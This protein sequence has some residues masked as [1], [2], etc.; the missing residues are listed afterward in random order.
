MLSNN[1]QQASVRLL[2]TW[3]AAQTWVATVSAALYRPGSLGCTT[4]R[5]A[6]RFL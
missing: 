3:P 2:L 6:W 1:A 4:E 5:H